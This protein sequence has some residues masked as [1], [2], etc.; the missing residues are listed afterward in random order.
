MQ[1]KNT[2]TNVELEKENF[3]PNVNQWSFRT[4]KNNIQEDSAMFKPQQ[5]DLG[6]SF[7]QKRLNDQNVKHS[8]FDVGFA[9][10]YTEYSS[11][12]M[13]DSH[14][15]LLQVFEEIKCGFENTEWIMNFNAIDNL[16]A[17]NKNY[18]LEINS[19]FTAFGN[20]ILNAINSPKPCLNKN[21][22]AFVYEV[23]LN[24][25]ESFI[26]IS[27]VLKFCEILIKKLNTSNGWLKNL[28]EK[29]MS[30]LLENCMC[31]AIIQAICELA[32]MK[33]RDINKIAFH[34]VVS[35]IDI[36]RER[37][38]ELQ[39]DTLRILFMT[40]AYNLESESTNNKR[41]AKDTCQYFNRLMKENY[42]NYVMYLY[43]NNYLNDRSVQNLAKAISQPENRSS[44]TAQ[45]KMSKVPLKNV[46][47]DFI[48]ETQRS[49]F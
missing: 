8:N 33:H 29:C 17:L 47:Y 5:T 25:K 27:I 42:E 49:G 41:L 15:D 3:S 14:V 18:P 48:C 10:T 44:L 19:I 36:L 7:C 11:L 28:V 45:G 31:D 20:F 16:R 22:L 6:P 9:V 24:A 35:A 21:I 12:P 39:P 2:S 37:V 40:I 4:L 46:K 1:F 23:F 43:N 13:F 34:Y 38:S 26:D 30:T 32:I